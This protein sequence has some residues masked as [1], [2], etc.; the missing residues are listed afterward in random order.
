MKILHNKLP[1]QTHHREH[2]R[3]LCLAEENHQQNEQQRADN[4]RHSPAAQGM[5]IPH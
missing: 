5:E 1:C 4:D 2:R 3:D